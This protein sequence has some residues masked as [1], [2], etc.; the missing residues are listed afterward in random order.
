[1]ANYTICNSTVPTA[2]VW[3]RYLS[4]FIFV[5]SFYVLVALIFYSWS[6]RLKKKICKINYLTILSGTCTLL[7]SFNKAAEHWI[8]YFSCIFY[9]WFGSVLYTVGILITYT[10]LWARQRKM[11]SDKLLAHKSS[12][13]IR[14]LSHVIISCIYC[15]FSI[16]C[17]LFTTTYRFRCDFQPCVLV[18]NKEKQALRLITT[19]IFMI[20]SFVF[21]S[22]LF[23]LLVYPI[24]KQKSC[25]AKFR[26]LFCSEAVDDVEK[27][28]KRLGFCTIACISSSL[29][30]CVIVIL[31]ASGVI[32]I[33]W[34]NL[35]TIDLFINTVATVT[36]F[37]DWRRRLFLIFISSWNFFCQRPNNPPLPQYS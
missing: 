6:N 9:H 33:F 34:C 24:I 17:M 12:K 35:L 3:E 22:A 4:I 37:V 20:M 2:Y 15:T 36:S 16:S 31:N 29:L 8:N 7:V 27:L 25:N 28:A 18:W 30:F 5:A 32:E 19:N 10:I 21:Q 26:A 1:M 11:Y 14:V 23:L 13:V